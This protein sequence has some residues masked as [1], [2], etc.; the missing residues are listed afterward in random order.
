MNYENRQAFRLAERMR[1]ASVVIVMAG[2]SWS[3]DLSGGADFTSTQCGTG[4]VC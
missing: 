4:T 3:S 2:V 1:A